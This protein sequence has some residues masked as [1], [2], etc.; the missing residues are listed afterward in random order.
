[1]A[2]YGGSAGGDDLLQR[3]TNRAGRQRRPGQDVKL[4]SQWSILQ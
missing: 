3:R 2:R 1:M 4:L